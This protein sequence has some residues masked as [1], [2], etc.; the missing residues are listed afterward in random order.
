MTSTSVDSMRNHLIALFCK[1]LNVNV[2]SKPSI[3]YI[4]GNWGLYNNTDVDK[5]VFC[6]T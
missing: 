3:I 1:R 4:F 2:L 5:N 6:R